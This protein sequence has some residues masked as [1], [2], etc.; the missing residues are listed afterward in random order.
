MP[1]DINIPE[2]LARP[3]LLEGDGLLPIAVTGHRRLGSREPY[4]PTNMVATKVKEL[5]GEEVTRIVDTN[6]LG[7]GFIGISG[8]A[9]GVD[10]LYAE[11]CIDMGLPWIAYVPC[12][13]QWNTWPPKAVARYKDLVSKATDIW[14]PCGPVP[15]SFA[16]MQ[17][18][19]EAMVRD[20]TG[21][22]AVWNGVAGGTANCAWFAATTII[23]PIRVLDPRFL[24]DGWVTYR[25]PESVTTV[26]GSATSAQP[27][28][29]L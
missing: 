25:L 27:E 29:V 16:C 26:M 20:C 28:V 13:K 6:P 4:N 8:M 3:T 21:L 2:D 19:N 10:Q 17:F 23:R 12:L 9:L 22:L 1:M 11:V 24:K 14:L 5:L 18:R 15:Y 7:A